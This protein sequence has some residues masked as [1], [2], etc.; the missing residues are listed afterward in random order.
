MGKAVSS[1]EGAI[2]HAIKT[3]HFVGVHNVFS[4]A[5]A[6]CAYV[7]ASVSICGMLKVMECVTMLWNA[8]F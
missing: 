2:P 4:L 7:R 1:F 8:A 6:I 3:M 5:C